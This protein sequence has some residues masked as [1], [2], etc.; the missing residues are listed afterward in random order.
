LF[1]AGLAHQPGW[2]PLA[3]LLVGRRPRA[4]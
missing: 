3:R 4:A 1:P 2:S